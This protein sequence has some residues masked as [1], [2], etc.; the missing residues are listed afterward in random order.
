MLTAESR[1]LDTMTGS[2][3]G[4]SAINSFTA[5]TSSCSNLPWRGIVCPP[6]LSKKTAMLSSKRLYNARAP[7]LYGSARVRLCY[8]ELR[9]RVNLPLALIMCKDWT[10]RRSSTSSDK[11]GPVSEMAGQP[12]KKIAALILGTYPS[13]FALSCSP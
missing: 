13:D 12:M 6:A 7:S 2:S 1:R 5:C 11:T 10:S 9:A 4:M 8:V 3:N